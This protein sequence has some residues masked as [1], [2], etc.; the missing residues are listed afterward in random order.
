MQ[1][2]GFKIETEK[3]GLSI[4]LDGD[5]VIVEFVDQAK[6]VIDSYL[7]ECQDFVFTLDEWRDQNDALSV[8]GE[9]GLDSLNRICAAIG[10]KE[11]RYEHG[12][13]LEE[14]LR[15]NPGAI[16]SVIEFIGELGD[17]TDWKDKI[18]SQ[19]KV[20]ECDDVRFESEES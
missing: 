15:D 8:E 7:D 17:K 14:F 13:P 11:Q 9:R 2:R 5:V 18:V 19:M 12:S 20:Q 10:Y 4:D 16:D 6:A 1:Y 3:F